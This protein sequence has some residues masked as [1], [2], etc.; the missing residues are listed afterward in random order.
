[1][2]TQRARARG[3]GLAGGPALAVAL[4]GGRGARRSTRRRGP[5][6]IERLAAGGAPSR[7]GVAAAATGAEAAPHGGRA[8]SSR[9]AGAA[10]RAPARST[11]RG[12][13]SACCSSTPG[14]SRTRGASDGA[15]PA[16]GDDA[17]PAVVADALGSGRLEDVVDLWAEEWAARERGARLTAPGASTASPAWC[18]RPGGAAVLRGGRAGCWRSGRRRGRGARGGARRSRRPS[19]GRRSAFPA[20]VDLRGLEVE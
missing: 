3:P 9:R 10:G 14:R 12:S 18:G 5:D 15:A 11:R 20:R 6:A 1:M 7:A 17:A 16:T 13:R 4:A 19:R 8:V 2:I